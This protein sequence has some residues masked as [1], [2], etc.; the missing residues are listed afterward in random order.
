[1]HKLFIR[2]ESSHPKN[3]LSQKPLESVGGGGR[4]NCLYDKDNRR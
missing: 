1:M 4:Q 3:M 2:I